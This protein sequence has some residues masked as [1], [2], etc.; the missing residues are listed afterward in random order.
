MRT[1]PLLTI[2]V[3][4]AAAC[5]GPAV[6]QYRD[7]L[8]ATLPPPVRAPDPTAQT[9][10]RF[11]AA[12]AAAGQPRMTILWNRAF[13]DALDTRYDAVTT[14]TSAA[15]HDAWLDVRR[16]GRSVEAGSSSTASTEIRSGQRRADDP[17]EARASLSE[18]EDWAIEA[19]FTA[20]LKSAGIRLIDRA[21]AMR[22][23]AAARTPGERQDIQTIEAQAL[24]GKSD[25][26]IEVLQS[27]DPQA[28]FG[29]HFRI[30]AK[31]VATGEVLALIV[32]AGEQTG[33]EQR[34]F[35]AGVSGFVRE[36]QPDPTPASMGTA[37]ANRILAALNRHWGR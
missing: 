2:A 16:R 29:L 9:M 15:D 32:D 36:Q 20:R 28:E 10:A 4:A 7:G 35:V 19:A 24:S 25:V 3:A 31:N 13:S 21:I 22:T 8:P 33:G 6:A 1:I 11:A 12:Y 14:V 5:S 23:E 26:L 30:E 17:P 27:H 18:R 34:R 37:L